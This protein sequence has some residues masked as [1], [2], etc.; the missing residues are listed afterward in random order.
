LRAPEGPEYKRKSISGYR[1]FRFD[2]V[3]RL[4]RFGREEKEKW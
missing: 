2:I 3:I 4:Q 1:K